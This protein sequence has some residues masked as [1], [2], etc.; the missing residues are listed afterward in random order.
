MLNV[1]EGIVD[2]QRVQESGV[3]RLK[4]PVTWQLLNLPLESYENIGAYLG[5]MGRAGFMNWI[6]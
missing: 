4:N 5:V 3:H 2:K 6:Q 1:D